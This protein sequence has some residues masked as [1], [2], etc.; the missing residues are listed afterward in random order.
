MAD[1][2]AD[3]FDHCGDTDFCD[4]VFVRICE[5]HGNGADVSRLTEEERTVSLVW[6]SLGV[7]GNGGF[8]YLFEGSV[9]GDPNYALTRRA[10]EAIGCPEAAEAFREALSAFPDCVPPV[11]QAKRER[12]YLHHF[13]GMGTSPDR[14]FYAAQDDI[15]KRLA[16]WLRSRNRPHPHL[17]KPE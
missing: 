3:L 5:V 13:P 6:G 2:L 15:P 12:A 8:R 10:F 7:I 1:T 4:R 16:N 11:N 14:A 9:R 17:A